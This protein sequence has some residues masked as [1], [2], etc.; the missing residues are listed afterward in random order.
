MSVKHLRETFEVLRHPKIILN[1]T[2]CALGVG[3]GKSMGLTVSKQGIEANPD[4]I[5]AILD[6]EPP[7]SMK[8]VQKL[9]GRVAALG[10][11]FPTR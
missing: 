3:S 8:D 10:S 1:P 6:M 4:K 9:K 7:S 11:S 5:K 2:E